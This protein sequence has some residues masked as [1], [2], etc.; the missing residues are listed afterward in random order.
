MS[1]G[2][3]GHALA[4]SWVRQEEHGVRL[5]VRVQP[6]ASRSGIV[7]LHD[8]ALKI[9]LA[10][11]PVDGAANRALVVYLSKRLGVPKSD[12]RIVRGQSGRLK[13]VQIQGLD[14]SSVRSRLGGF[15]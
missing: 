12:I 5:R 3:R 7:G 8:D 14:L 2:L 4:L 10:A 13:S 9:R 15:D 1:H 11:P 6:R